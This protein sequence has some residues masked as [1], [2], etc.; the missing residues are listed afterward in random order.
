LYE[1][2]K[3]APLPSLDLISSNNQT[4]SLYIAPREMTIQQPVW[5]SPTS[6]RKYTRA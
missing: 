5:S 2:I 3:L 6:S 1:A 4:H